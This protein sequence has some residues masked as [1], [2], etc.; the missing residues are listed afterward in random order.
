M[1]KIEVNKLECRFPIFFKVIWWATLVWLVAAIV[2]YFGQYFPL[3]MIDQLG[4]GIL[5]CFGI[6]L[7]ASFGRSI[8]QLMKDNGVCQK[9]KATDKWI[10]I[11]F[12]VC[13]GLEFL[14]SIIT[15][16]QMEKDYIIN[17]GFTSATFEIIWAIIT[18]Y[19]Q[20]AI[21]TVILVSLYVMSKFMFVTCSG[22]I[23]RLGVEIIIAVMIL[24][25]LSFY[26]NESILACILVVAVAT[27]FLYDIWRIADF[28]DNQ[29]FLSSDRLKTFIKDEVLSE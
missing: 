28:S 24:I 9:S 14:Y 23:R 29:A 10:S 8:C 26:E 25:Y 1:E 5:I 17:G 3:S 21:M 16:G 20:A 7:Y 15:M 27:S 19:I 22:R 18:A 2:D 13:F 6:C 12:L 11:L 4:Y